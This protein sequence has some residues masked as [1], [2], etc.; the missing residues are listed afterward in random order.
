MVMAIDSGGAFAPGGEDT[1]ALLDRVRTRSDQARATYHDLRADWYLNIAFMLNHQ[2]TEVDEQSGQ[3]VQPVTPQWR[4]RAV[5]NIIAPTVDVYVNRVTSQWPTF[6]VVPATA[7]DRDHDAATVGGHAL[8]YAARKIKLLSKIKAAV[9]YAATCGTGFLIP[10]Y[11][12]AARF[13]D[14]DVPSPFDMYPEPGAQSQHDCHWMIRAHSFAIEEARLRFKRPDLQA[15]HGFPE[16]S[17][18]GRLLKSYESGGSLDRASGGRAQG[19]GGLVTP[20]VAP[21]RGSGVGSGRGRY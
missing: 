13:L 17:V 4:Q 3:L 6:R 2:Y 1:R 14:V 19:G 10:L 9:Q 7:E 15:N 5:R 18:T 20:P 21:L 8:E 12:A 11:D 16:D